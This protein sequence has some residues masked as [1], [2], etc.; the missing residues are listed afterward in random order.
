MNNQ[1]KQDAYKVTL[2]NTK[3]IFQPNFSGEVRGP[4]DDGTR[5]VNIIIDEANPD[6]KYGKPSK[7]NQL[8]VE[9]LVNDGWNVRFREANDDYPEQAF[10][11]VKVAYKKRNGEPVKRPP[12][13]IKAIGGPDYRVML[14]EDSV[15]DLDNEFIENV[16]HVDIRGWEYEEGKISAY[17]VNMYVTVEDDPFMREYGDFTSNPQNRVDEE[18]DLPF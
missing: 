13:I 12:Q 10:I 1:K 8:K 11:K 3:F 7:M 17:L 4:Y 5:Y 15:G 14:D 18:D 16:E 6:N 2:K 9:D